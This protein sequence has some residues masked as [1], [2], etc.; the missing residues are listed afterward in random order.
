LEVV[1]VEG[2]QKLLRDKRRKTAAKV[3]GGGEGICLLDFGK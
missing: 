3:T 1:E 2:I